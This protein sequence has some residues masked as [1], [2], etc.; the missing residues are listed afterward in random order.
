MGNQLRASAKYSF[1]YRNNQSEL[2]EKAV[3]NDWNFSINWTPSPKNNKNNPITLAT[4]LQAKFSYIQ[5]EFN[6]LANT[7]IA[8]AML[9][10]LQDGQNLLWGLTID[11]QIS[12]TIQL[13]LNYEGRRTGNQQG[14]VHVGRMQLRALF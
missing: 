3:Q 12:K 9:D 8:F 7:P 11:R 2:A 14:I 1:K 4:N 6:G 13:N 10:G 5:I